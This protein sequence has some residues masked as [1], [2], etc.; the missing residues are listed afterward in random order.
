V[1]F[2]RWAFSDLRDN[3]THGILAGFLVAKAV[4]GEFYV[5]AADRIRDAKTKSVNFWLGD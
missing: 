1:D 4:G 5:V 3:I 2:W